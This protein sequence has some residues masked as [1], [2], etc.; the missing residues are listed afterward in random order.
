[1]TAEYDS[2]NLWVRNYW[3]GQ[4]T[5][6]GMVAGGNACLALLQ[7]HQCHYLLSDKRQA[8]GLWDETMEWIT[9]SWT[10]R[11][12]AAG[13]THLAQVVSVESLPAHSSEI[14]RHRLEEKCYIRTFSGMAE[15][16]AWLRAAQQANANSPASITH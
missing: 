16:Q 5:Y 9:T 8:V 13:M 1:M 2:E 14:M 3:Q 10:P 12:V 11:A 15:A 4:Q 6:V 7:Q